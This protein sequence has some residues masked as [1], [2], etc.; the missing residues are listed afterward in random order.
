MKTKVPGIVLI[1]VS[2]VLITL[3]ITF[4]RA[5][6]MPQYIIFFHTLGG[7]SLVTGITLLVLSRQSKE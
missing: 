6:N 2:L 5:L 3:G 1:V 7:L 4:K